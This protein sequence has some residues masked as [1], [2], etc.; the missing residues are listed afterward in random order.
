MPTVVIFHDGVAVDKIIG[1][2]GLA[3]GMPE[4]KEDEVHRT[5]FSRCITTSLRMVAVADGDP[6]EV[7]GS[8]KCHQQVIDRRRRRRSGQFPGE[9]GGIAEEHI[10]EVLIFGCR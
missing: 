1:F 10:C 8:Q 6:G 4:G 9:A 2:D 3:D 5:L 7:I